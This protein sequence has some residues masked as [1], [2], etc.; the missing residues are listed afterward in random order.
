MC[1]AAACDML[2]PLSAFIPSV[3]GMSDHFCQND[4]LIRKYI[5]TGSM[6]KDIY[7]LYAQQAG[8]CQCRPDV[9]GFS[10]TRG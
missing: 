1:R 9:S 2:F 6:Q 8:C 4:N 10:K 7:R 3:G 5:S